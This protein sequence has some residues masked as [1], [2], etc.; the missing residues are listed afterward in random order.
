MQRIGEVGNAGHPAVSD[1]YREQMPPGESKN[2]VLT[3]GLMR[4]QWQ[5]AATR[6]FGKDI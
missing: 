1:P 2:V 3:Y 4:E 6:L 5:S